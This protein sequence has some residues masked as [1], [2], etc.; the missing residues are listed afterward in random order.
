[1][2]DPISVAAIAGL[3]YAGR[4]LSQPKETYT[5]TPEQVAPK[6]EPSYKI[7][8][9][10]ER[11]IENLKPTKMHV[12]NFGVVAPQLRSSGQEVLNMQNRMNDY[13]RM[14]NVSPVE[15]RLVGP[16]LGVDPSVPSYGGYQQLLRVNP[17]NVGAY[18][19]TTLPG[20]SGPAQDV[21][22]GRRGVVGAIGNNRPEKTTFLPERLPMTLGRAQGFSGRVTRGSHERTKRTTNRS[23]TGLRTDTLNVAPAKRFISAQN[24]SQDPT[25]NKKDG[26]ME[27]YQYMNQTQPGIHSFAHGYLA[28]PEIAIG[29]S[30][31]YTPEQLSR[32]GF[33]PDERRGKA[34][35]RSN[36]GRM[37]VRAGPL[38][39]GGMITSARSDTTRVDGRVN[40]LAGGWM[41]QY[42]NSSFHDLNTYKGNQNPHASQG[43]LGV[44]KRQLM[45]NPYAHHLC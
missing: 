20:R 41:Q 33:R 19:L 28:S 36:P 44:A 22:G 30:K 17:E 1:M 13:N 15:K 12:D 25:R 43:S 23:Q 8:P 11:P 9:V 26:N 29:G 38:N 3:V 27:Q 21:S 4:K 6:I 40:P 16:G 39:Q 5:I 35:R 42:T 24:V 14:N 10:K 31:A 34:N 7:E 32:Y 45:N 2:A 37:N 18:R